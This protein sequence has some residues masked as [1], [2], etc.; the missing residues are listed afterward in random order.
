MG[1]DF[2]LAYLPYCDVTEERGKVLNDI[3]NGLSEKDIEDVG[4]WTSWEDLVEAKEVIQ[5][6]IETYKDNN[7]SGR[8]DVTWLTL[9]GCRYYFSGGMSWGD[10][11]TDAYDVIMIL[12][13]ISPIFD[14]LEK[15]CREDIK[16]DRI[17]KVGI[18]NA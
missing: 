18:D 1:A 9:G 8:R 16:K 14:T 11:P 13:Q 5:D 3:V 6:Y 7:F 10:S 15:W 17:D 2:L 12:S 4:N